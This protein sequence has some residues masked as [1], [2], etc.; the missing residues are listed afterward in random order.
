MRFADFA[1]DFLRIAELDGNSPGERKQKAWALDNHLLDHFGEWPLTSI[2][3]PLIREFTAMKVSEGLAPKT[4]NNLLGHLARFLHVAALEGHLKKADLPA[5]RRLPMSATESRYLLPAEASAL[6]DAASTYGMEWGNPVYKPMIICALNTGLR[7]GEL[8]ALEWRDVDFTVNRIMVRRSYCRTEN[9][10]K[11]TKTGHHRA[12]SLNPQAVALLRNWSEL[13][14]E[15]PDKVFAVNYTAA[16]RALL[17]IADA[18]G[19]ENVGW[20]TLRHTF[21]SWLVTAG[22]PIFTVSKMLGHQSMRMTERY[23]HLNSEQNLAAA[24][25]ISNILENV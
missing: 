24:S 14:A 4:V 9:K 21:A 13:G 12:V 7:V 20:H 6:I 3:V 22:V 25:I 8:I 23:A 16:H 15:G 1:A 11:S 17:R 19:L 10:T 18:A 5:I 2:G